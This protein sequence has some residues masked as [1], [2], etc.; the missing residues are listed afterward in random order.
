MTD[1]I[2]DLFECT[3]IMVVGDNKCNTFSKSKCGSMRIVKDINKFSYVLELFNQ[4]NIPV[5]VK[6]KPAADYMV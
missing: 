2:S 1:I 3:S 5:N 6:M 4:V